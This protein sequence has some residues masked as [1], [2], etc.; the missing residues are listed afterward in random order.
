MAW[1]QTL[2]SVALVSLASLVG[3]V[4]LAFDEARVRRLALPF[5]SFAAGALLGDTFLHLVPEAY[6]KAGPGSLSPGTLIL[7]GVLSF[8]GLEKL[9]R[10]EHG[11]L[12]RRA[13]PQA[14]GRPELAAINLVGDGVHNF[15]DG[16]LIAASYLV[17]PTLGLTTT[18]AVFL[19]ELP[20]ELGDFAVLIH[21][22]LTVRRALLL[23][24]LTASLAVA[25]AVLTLALGATTGGA[26]SQVLVPF[27][28]GGFLYIATADLIPELQHD[29]TLRGLLAQAGMMTLGLGLMAALRWM[30][31]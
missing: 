6:A 19:H 22:G 26:L 9:L 11:P 12:H 28:A 16:A 15:V 29:R 2:L 18:L 23:N 31:Q 1:A 3:L 24:L 17:S 4:T 30:D 25:G 20:Q 5:V 21:S 27:T 13:H 10:H 14:G 8:F 7:A